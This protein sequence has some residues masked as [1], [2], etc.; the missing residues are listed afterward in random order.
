MGYTSYITCTG[1][2]WHLL[3]SPP[4]CKRPRASIQWIQLLHRYILLPYYISTIFISFNFFLPTV[5]ALYDF[6]KIRDYELSFTAG[7]I[8][9][10]VKKNS[11]G[12]YWHKGVANGVTGIFPANYVKVI[13][14]STSMYLTL[15]TYSYKSTIMHSRLL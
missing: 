11:A 10:V 12:Q 6:T 14:V 1:D 5:V 13:S 7:T 9:Y 15:Y 2:A 3:T 4:A 8:I